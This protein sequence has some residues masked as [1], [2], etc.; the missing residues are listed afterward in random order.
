MPLSCVEALLVDVEGISFSQEVR[1]AGLVGWFMLVDGSNWRGWSVSSS[2]EARA[3]ES[4][5][6]RL[7]PRLALSSKTVLWLPNAPSEVGATFDG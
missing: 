7:I 6:D 1:R 4:G 2:E 3:S 5:V